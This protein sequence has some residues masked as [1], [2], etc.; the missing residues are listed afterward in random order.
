M[1]GKQPFLVGNGVLLLGIARRRI[2]AHYDRKERVR[3]P[4]PRL[5]DR[6][7]HPGLWFRG[8]RA[9]KGLTQQQVIVMSGLS[10]QRVGVASN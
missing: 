8:E 5:P 1:A 9:F 6:I 2:T 7:D 10:G 4:R 3:V